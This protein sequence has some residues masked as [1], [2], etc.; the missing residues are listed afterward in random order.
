[1]GDRWSNEV[2]LALE[3]TGR[4]S[5]DLTFSQG[6]REAVGH[7]DVFRIFHPDTQALPGAAWIARDVTELRVTEAALRSANADLKQFKALVEA[8]PDFI[9]IAGLDERSSTSTPAGGCSSGWTR[10]ST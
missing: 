3:T 9:A 6:D 4:W 1:M 8:S 2:R 5:G 7:L 10:P